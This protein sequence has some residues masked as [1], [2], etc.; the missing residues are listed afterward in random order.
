MFDK[1][2][3]IGLQLRNL[4][5]CRNIK[6]QNPTPLDM[7]TL[8][9]FNTDMK[10]LFEQ[11]KGNQAIDLNDEQ[12]LASINAHFKNLYDLKDNYL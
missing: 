3:S 6:M 5:T 7:Q 4:F 2:P 10:T 9:K 1:R 8:Q 11:I 12:V